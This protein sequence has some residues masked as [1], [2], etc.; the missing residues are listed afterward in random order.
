MNESSVLAPTTEH[1]TQSQ[2]TAASSLE[3]APSMFLL[4][5]EESRERLQYLDY[6]K[7][8]NA[9][10][11]IMYACCMYKHEYEVVCYSIIIQMPVLLMQKE[12]V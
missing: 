5:G 8:P 2:I 4:T 7:K 1:F 3:A 11:Y 9:D 6:T 12:V 10:T